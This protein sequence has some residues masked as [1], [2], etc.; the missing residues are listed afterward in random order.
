MNDPLEMMAAYFEGVLNAAQVAELEAYLRE[1]P[2]HARTFVQQAM[3][4]CHL[5]EL[6]HE[7]NV[8]DIAADLS[9]D[10]QFG[11]LLKELDAPDGAAELVNIDVELTRLRQQRDKQDKP[12][13]ASTLT[14]HEIAA[15]SG[16]LLR[17]A[18]VSRPAM[19]AYAA[20]IVL[21]VATLLIPWNSNPTP[22]TAQTNTPPKPA[23]SAQPTPHGSDT[24]PTPTPQTVATLT[25][26]HNALWA[27][28]PGP[29]ASAAR[30]N[31]PTPG[32]P[33]HP[34]TRLTLTTGFAEITTNR[35][36]IAILEAPATVEL[37]D[38]DN[39][40]RLHAGKLVGICETESSEGFVVRTPH[41]NVTDLGTRFGVDVSPY[42]STEVHVHQGEV[43]IATPSTSATGSTQKQLISANQAIRYEAS[44]SAVV[45]I[46]PAFDKF[47]EVL[48]TYRLRGTG[49]H[50]AEGEVDPNW[51]VVADA[52]GKLDT[53]LPVV[54]QHS[55]KDPKFPHYPAVGNDPAIA[56]WLF[57]STQNTPYY[58]FDTPAGI[59]STRLTFASTFQLPDTVELDG[60]VLY[61]RYASPEGIDELRINGR[62]IEGLPRRGRFKGEQLFHEV[63]LPAAQINLH[64]GENRIEIDL[65]N[66]ITSGQ[67]SFYLQWELRPTPSRP[68]GPKSDEA[69]PTDQRNQP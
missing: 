49:L 50:L 9:D 32:T 69:Q 66:K 21:F 12:G 57:F 55:G 22:Q 58:L 1:D 8:T 48:S 43:V 41:M 59:D 25:A 3:L 39:A 56:Q 51:H 2:K 4:D 46:A 64:P 45:S 16:Y 23:D 37:L 34:N 65:A 54:I 6:L 63:E 38:N 35:G 17:Q 67:D 33:L 27:P 7:Q 47:D 42:R 18:L 29:A 31:P 13:E 68:D 24:Q 36:A 52:N 44:R 62:A 40:L 20:A 15:V 61:L 26:T 53:P 30:A 19:Y 28:A 5:G 60:K 11:A 14:A 10:S